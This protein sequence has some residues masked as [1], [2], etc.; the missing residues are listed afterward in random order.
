[1]GRVDHGPQRAR[2]T[3]RISILGGAAERTIAEA[4]G[5]IGYALRRTDMRGWIQ[6]GSDDVR[7]GA[8]MGEILQQPRALLAGQYRG[9]VDNFRV[10]CRL[11]NLVGSVNRAEGVGGGIHGYV[12]LRAVGPAMSPPIG[13]REGID[14][15][16]LLRAWAV[17]NGANPSGHPWGQAW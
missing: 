8:A 12:S 6:P 14:R 17:T 13:R 16:V 1:V 15:D 4:G 2:S 7:A 11:G 5:D 10:D 3:S 9:R